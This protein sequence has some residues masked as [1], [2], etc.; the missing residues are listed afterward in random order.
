MTPQQ[1][2]F[3]KAASAIQ[4][5]SIKNIYLNELCLIIKSKLIVY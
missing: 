5:K 2:Q 4:R 1:H 3:L